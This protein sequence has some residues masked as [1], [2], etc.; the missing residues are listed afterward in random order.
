V[1]DPFLGT[2]T[3]I[4]AAIRH[5]RR[6]IG[7]ETLN[8]YIELAKQRIQQEIDG[9]LRTRPMDRPIY[10]PIEAGNNLTVAPWEK[11][12]KQMT[13]LENKLKYPGKKNR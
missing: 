10:D 7:A 9:T 1:L 12:S 3:T 13:L 2:G 11:D 8:K 4:I 5:G 6:G